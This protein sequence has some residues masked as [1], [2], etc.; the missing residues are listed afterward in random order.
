MSSKGLPLALVG[1]TLLACTTT[2]SVEQ[3]ED[4]DSY[5]MGLPKLEVAP[6]Q[7]KT[8]I[9]CAGACP[10]DEQAGQ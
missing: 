5:I 4:V 2:D 7:P 10:A 9:D 8:Q 1:L 6:A 3:T